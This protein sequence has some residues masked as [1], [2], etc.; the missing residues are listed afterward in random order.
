MHFCCFYKL[1]FFKEDL[2]SKTHH[3]FYGIDDF[4]EKE[5]RTKFYGVLMSSHEVMKLYIYIFQLKIAVR[6]ET[7]SIK[8]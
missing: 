6:H 7:L 8:I 2:R 1:Y 3:C 4:M 5:P